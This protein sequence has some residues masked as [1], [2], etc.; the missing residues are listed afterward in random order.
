MRS[1]VPVSAVGSSLV[2]V[3]DVESSLVGLSVVGSSLSEV[4][5]SETSCEGDGEEEVSFSSGSGA[6]WLQINSTLQP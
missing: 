3:S 1:R 2:G 5:V 4:S 6:N